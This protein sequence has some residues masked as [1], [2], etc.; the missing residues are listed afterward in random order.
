M[1]IHNKR[2][3]Q[4][5]AI[6]HSADIDYNDFMK[7]YKKYT[8]ETYSFLT[9]DTTLPA[10]NSLRFRRKYFR[11]FIKMTLTD[12]VK[13]LDGKIK[14]NQAQHVLDREVGKLSVL[15]S[16][17]LDKY[18]YLTGENLGYKPGVVEKVKFGYSPLGEALNKGLKKD[19]KVNK[20][21][22]YNN[23]LMYDSL[24]NFNKYSVPSFNKI[25][26]IDSNLIH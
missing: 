5:V 11:F 2:E 22:K 8:S 15:S 9:I 23:D 4:Q 16:K 12:D 3:L 6:N 10:K 1:K 17:E 26:S 20:V 13:I 25:S 24:H 19:D 18:E 14:A 21:I 7:I